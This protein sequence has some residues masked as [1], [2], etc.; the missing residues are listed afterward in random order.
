[1]ET[2]VLNYEVCPIELMLETISPKYVN[3]YIN[4]NLYRI[5][6]NSEGKEKF[7]FLNLILY[8]FSTRRNFKVVY[9][10]IPQMSIKYKE[11]RQ[12]IYDNFVDALIN[13]PYDS[14][15]IGEYISYFG[16]IDNKKAKQTL[17]DFIKETPVTDLRNKDCGKLIKRSNDI[18][19]NQKLW[20]NIIDNKPSWGD[21]NYLYL[22]TNDYKLKA[23]KMLME[24]YP[25][26]FIRRYPYAYSEKN[27]NASKTI[28]KDV[29]VN[30]TFESSEY[31]DSLNL[32]NKEE[33]FSMVNEYDAVSYLP[34]F[35]NK[36]IVI[37][38]GLKKLNET[39]IRVNPYSMY[40]NEY[41]VSVKKVV[42]MLKD[43]FLN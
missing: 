28:K 14:I 23:G 27:T 36:Y 43:D 7:D 38:F 16:R 19:F 2:N 33:F 3:D 29:A 39:Q 37:T 42:K 8:N 11:Y 26:R 21:L 4:N 10:E 25:S 41:G 32:I 13:N 15:T 9:R 31:I 17:L 1:M 20:E 24:L 22:F 5:I 40:K 12:I 18:S 34:S 35:D 30:N 6:N